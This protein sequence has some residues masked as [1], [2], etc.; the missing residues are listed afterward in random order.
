MNPPSPLLEEAA[1]GMRDD[2]GDDMEADPPT[3]RM[4][5]TAD[6]GRCSLWTGRV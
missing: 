2:L 4:V 3:N 1:A 5:L 6:E